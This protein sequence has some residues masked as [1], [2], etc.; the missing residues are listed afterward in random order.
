MTMYLATVEA[1][2]PVRA[3]TF[4]FCSDDCR[5]RYW[6]WDEQIALGRIELRDDDHYE[7]DEYCANCGEV[8][9][10]VQS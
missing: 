5:A 6:T 4:P 2:H 3:A 10:A 8:I 9:E 7:F 1:S